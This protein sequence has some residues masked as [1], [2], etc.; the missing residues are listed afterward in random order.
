MTSSNI[1]LPTPLAVDQLSANGLLF[2]GV[3]AVG[4]HLFY[5][6]G[7]LGV[8]EVHEEM[9]SVHRVGGE[10]FLKKR[11][12]ASYSGAA[13]DVGEDDVGVF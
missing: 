2:P 12:G 9:D 6:A 3:V 8:F 11:F 5:V 4:D 1:S 7:V 13:G 10:A